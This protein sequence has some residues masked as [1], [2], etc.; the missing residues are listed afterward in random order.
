MRSIPL[1]Q[2]KV[3]LVDDADFDWLSRWKWRAVEVKQDHWSLWYAVRSVG[4]RRNSRHVQMHRQILGVRGRVRVDHRDCDGLN[5][6]RANLRKSTPSQNVANQ[7]KRPGLS[8][9][10]KGVSWDRTRSQ[11]QSH[12]TLNG[13]TRR[14][15]RFLDEGEAALAYNAAAEKCFGEF[16]RPNPL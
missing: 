12:I 14:L 4:P 11:W 6:Q 7:R 9:R 16:A 3:A 1:T 8:S 13:R 2:G 15:G 5:N 10:F